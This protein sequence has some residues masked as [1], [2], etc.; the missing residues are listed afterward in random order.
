MR[1]VTTFLLFSI[2]LMTFSLS[3]QTQQK[4]L[5]QYRQEPSPVTASLVKGSIYEVKGGRGANCGFFNK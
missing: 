4:Q 2:L 3:A 5:P 1:K